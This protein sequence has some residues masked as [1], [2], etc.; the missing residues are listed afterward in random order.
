MNTDLK[1]RIYNA[2]CYVKIEPG[3]FKVPYPN[4]FS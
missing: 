4:I 2:Q 1:D 3:E